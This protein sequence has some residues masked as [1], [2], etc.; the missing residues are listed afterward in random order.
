MGGVEQKEGETKRMAKPRARRV[1]STGPDQSA[2]PCSRQGKFPLCFQLCLTSHQ[3]EKAKGKVTSQL[4]RALL[5]RGQFWKVSMV[6]GETVAA[7]GEEED[8]S[9]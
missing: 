6:P 1:Y 4:C 3:L 8:L 5:G 9:E 7:K 2:L